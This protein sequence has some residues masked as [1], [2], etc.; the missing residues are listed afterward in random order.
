MIPD[1][2]IDHNIK[3]DLEVGWENAD[4]IHLARDGNKW[5]DLAFTLM[6]LGV[7]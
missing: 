6:I 3:T 5:H 1:I 2:T 4:F 7:P